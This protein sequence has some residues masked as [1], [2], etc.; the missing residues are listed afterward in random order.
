MKFCEFKQCLAF[1]DEDIGGLLLLKI[2]SN[3]VIYF[4]CNS[5]N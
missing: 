3:Y 1:R 2:L 4:L 5:K